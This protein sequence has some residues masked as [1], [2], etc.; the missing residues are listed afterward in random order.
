M[1]AALAVVLAFAAFGFSW[2]EALPAS[3]TTATGTGVARSRPAAYWMWGDLAALAFC[4]GPL[5]GRRGGRGWSPR[6]RAAARD[7]HRA[8][9]AGCPAPAVA[10]VLLADLSQMSKAEVERI[11]LPFV[12]WLLLSCALLPERWRRPALVVQVGVRAGRAAPAVHRLVSAPAISRS[13]SSRTQ[14]RA[15]GSSACGSVTPSRCPSK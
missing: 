10:M 14:A 7:R 11:W 1:V 6:P 15:A 8:V 2:W 13:D 9:A 3:C 12:P 5:A 4:A